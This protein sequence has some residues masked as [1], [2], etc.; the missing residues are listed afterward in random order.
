MKRDGILKS[1]WQDLP[2][3]H[4]PGAKET[5]QHYDVIIAGGGITGVTTAYRLQKSGKKV[6]LLEAH[7]IGFGTTGG[8]TSFINNYFDSRY[9]D[10]EKDFGADQAK[11]LSQCGP[12]VMRFIRKVIAEHHIE[13][14]HADPVPAFLYSLDEKQDKALAEEYEA[15]KR[16]ELSVAQV[17]GMAFALPHRK[18]IKIEGQAQFHPLK[19]IN[20]L[21]EEF[22][23]MGGTLET[24]VRVL[25]VSGDDEKVTVETEGQ[26]Y[27][28][29]HFVW[30]THN[31]VGYNR[32]QFNNAPY[33][34][35]VIAFKVKNGSYP[36]IQATDMSDTYYYF[37]SQK[38]DDEEYIIAGGEDHKTGQEDDTEQR[39]RSLEQ[40]TAQYFDIEEVK[41][42][43]SSQYYIPADG[44]P[45]I[46]H[47][48]GEKNI[49]MATGYS[50][51]GI[52]FGTL[53][54]LIIA[55]LITT[56]SNRF[57]ELFKPSRIKPIAAAVDAIKENANVAY[58]LLKDKIFVEK[59][60]D[61]D[62]IPSGNGKVVRHDGHTL[63]VYRDES[64][65]ITALNSTCTHMG[66]NVAFNPSEKSWD[67][68]CHGARY[69]LEGQVLTGPAV[70]GLEKI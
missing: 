23:K 6:L 39:F 26:H 35:Y 32:F 47:F 42:R 49:F 44:L 2:R 69:D 64:G 28:V 13:C 52:T 57:G 54:G 31:M 3:E 61:L 18:M 36:R 55:D 30:A 45:Y 24:G 1:L 25:N 62:Q 65:G 56:G 48:P 40:Y 50:G 19:F 14:D 33:R 60:K 17:T 27:T 10:V 37:R 43:W 34:S 53:A 63:A 9:T 67:C 66:C 11:L 20:G 4:E 7:N 70:R 38:I 12:E 51:N 5:S 8:T 41:Y 22:I 58:T 68:P 16:V 29:P 21:V 59:I 15:M 46:G